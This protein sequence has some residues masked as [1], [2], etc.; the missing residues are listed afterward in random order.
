MNARINPGPKRTE[1]LKEY[2]I[3]KYLYYI[4]IRGYYI[5]LLILP[6][7]VISFI[8]RY[9]LHPFIFKKETRFNKYLRSA[10]LWLGGGLNRAVDY[11]AHL[12]IMRI[13][14][15]YLK[16][17]I[18]PIKRRSKP[19]VYL[20]WCV[21]PEFLRAFDVHYIIPE[22]YS[23]TGSWMGQ[24]VSI[25]LLETVEAEGGSIE[26][27]SA[28]KFGGGAYFTG[29]MP[30]PDIIV[31]SSHPCDSGVSFYPTVENLTGAPMFVLDT[32]YDTTE[33]AYRYFEKNLRSMI[34][35]IEKN[36][37]QKMDWNKLK[38]SCE[39]LNRTNFYL[40]ELT[41]MT[42]AIPSPVS[43]QLLTVAWAMKLMGSGSPHLTEMARRM[44]EASKKRL[45]RGEGWVKDEKIRVIWW[46]VPI[47]YISLYPWLE[48]EFGAMVVGGDLMGRCNTP[49]V[50]TST[51]ESMML[52]LAKVHLHASMVRNVRGTYELF[53]DEFEQIISEYSGDCFIF[54]G[55]NGCKHGWG[56]GRIK[57]D[58]CKRMGMPALHMSSDYSDCRNTSEESLK[59]Q[60]TDFF[61]GNGLA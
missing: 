5:V 18:E 46:D 7:S 29:Q 44:Y 3:A 39:E 23:V 35:F 56:Y 43:S 9:I 19:L 51:E 15:E 37:G 34:K 48:K 17:N 20:G 12:P 2:Q 11:R 1:Q 14:L 24:D 16:H 45:E 50:D 36:T 25:H 38:A 53:M 21:S 8:A 52:S 41:A 49:Y 60:I 10:L 6:Y 26:S 61:V 55:H 40:Q 31:T 47:A 27:C 54:V 59:K 42:R 13:L 4:L 28:S 58:V 32:P 30:D 22:A 33:G 57:K